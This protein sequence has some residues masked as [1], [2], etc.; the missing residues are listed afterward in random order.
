M[1]KNIKVGLLTHSLYFRSSMDETR[2]GQ[3]L[4]RE[5]LAFV[6]DV[7][8]RNCSNISST[9]ASVIPIQ[10]DKTIGNI[11]VL[12]GLTAFVFLV[13]FIRGLFTFHVL[14]RSSGKLHNKML[15]TIMRSPVLFF[16]SNP[17][18]QFEL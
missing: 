1:F 13:G 6:D 10:D 11:Y 16:D 17:T 3:I 15:D 4:F 14:L 2:N 12:V 18:G 5:R 8:C 9:N 7:F